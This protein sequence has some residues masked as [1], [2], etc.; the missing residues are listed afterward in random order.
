MVTTVTTTV[1]VNLID[2]I[3]VTAGPIVTTAIG[4]DVIITATTAAMTD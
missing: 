1:T 2:V 3:T 4:I